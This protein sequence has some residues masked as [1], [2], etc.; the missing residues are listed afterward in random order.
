MTVVYC[1]QLPIRGTASDVVGIISETMFMK[2][3]SDRR[4]VTS[5]KGKIRSYGQ[6]PWLCLGFLI[7]QSKELFGSRILG[8]F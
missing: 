5:V 4:T 6:T 2:T 3:V 1:N 8:L 7:V